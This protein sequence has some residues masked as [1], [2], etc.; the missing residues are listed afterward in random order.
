MNRVVAAIIIACTGLAACVSDLDTTREPADT[1]S[2]GNTVLTLVCKRIAYLEDLNDGDDIVDVRGDTFRDICRLGLAPP[3]AAPEELKALQAKRDALVAA[4]DTIFPE[5]FLSDLQTFLTSNEFL[6]LYDSGETMQAVDALIEFLR[7]LEA[8][9][10]LAPALE[11]FSLRLGYMP[12]TQALGAVRAFVNYPDLHEFLL[13]V[14]DQ[15]T[16]GG[17]AK[18]EWDNLI[19]GAAITMRA[20][21][22]PS[23]ANTPERTGQLA[24]DLLFEP[25]PLLDTSRTIPLVRRD[26]RGVAKVAMIGGSL[27]APFV[28]TDNDGLADVDDVGRFVDASNTP[29]AAPT[30][31]SLPSGEEQV[32]WLYRDAEGRALDSDG[33]Q[34]VYEY[35]DL[36][37]TMFA[38]LA[39]DS[40]QLFDPQ[41]GTALDLLRGASVLMGPRQLVTRAYNNGESIEYRGY[42]TSDAPILDMVHGYLSLMTDPNIYDVLAL[43][44]EI[45]TNHEQSIARILEAL[46]DTA[47]VGDAHPE[48]VIPTTSP[49]FDDL[50]PVIRQILDKPALARGLMRALENTQVAELGKRFRDYMKYKDQFTINPNNQAVVGSFST[51][52]DRNKSDSGYDRSLW[53]RLLHLIADS[54][55]AVLCNKDG[56]KVDLPGTGIGIAYYDECKLLRIDNLAV[57]YVQ[58]IAYAKDSNGN[59]II[60]GNGKPLPKA[61]FPFNLDD[62]RLGLPIAWAVSDDTLENESGIEGFRFNP[63]PE[64]LNRTLFL[65][66]MPTFLSNAMDPAKC[67]DGDLFTSAHGGTLPVWE[68]DGFYDQ[69]RPIV[70]VFADNNAEQLFVDMMVV[71]HK[72][73]PS[74][75][76]ITHQTTNPNGHGYAWGSGAVSYEPLLVDVLERDKLLPALV[77]TASDLNSIT[78]N[79]KSMPRIATEAARYM[80]TPQSGLAKRDG[81]TSTTTSD[82]ETVATLSPWHLLADAYQ[83]KRARLDAAG[84]EGGTWPSATSNLVD[85]LIRA[86]AVPNLGWTFRNPRFR[87]ISVGL[88]NFLEKRLQAHDS[89]SDRTDWL[90]TQLPNR[91]EEILSS[92]LFA[93]A[94][95]FFLSLQ[96]SPEARQQIEALAAYLVNEVNY[97]DAF[98]TSLSA[99]ADM[100]QLALDD[101]DILPI[102]RVVGEA[103]K[104]ERGWLNTHLEWVK[105]VRHSDANQ[106]LVRM[107]RN[108]YTEHRPG[109]TAVSDLIDGISE[110]KR[111]DP[112]EDL[113]KDYTAADYKALLLGVAG[114]LDEE[115]RGLRKFIR[116][117]ESRNK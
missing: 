63:T 100:L 46:V 10:D 15:I 28:D 24:L 94:A 20:A 64:A 29:V 27:P 35:L 17:Q 104:P 74:K 65:Q 14:G 16:E 60:G 51:P 58:S 4:V 23:D 43:S 33:G 39:R 22:T 26:Q 52:V 21:E 32:P 115:K 73:W 77:Y 50:V 45:F 61:R 56:A 116:I 44:R 48:A 34:P 18:V 98:M 101:R 97:N 88:I 19:R 102:A 75:D 53:Q 42:D 37:G 5:S 108:L 89:A 40:I 31:F 62:N 49:L 82:G 103:L 76:S 55:K 6:A 93:G 107:L 68:K 9:P 110:V 111:A 71:L 109:H 30:P 114:F 25:N 12:T 95:D 66:P 96:A 8:E 69:I 106:A 2:F 3:A 90:L 54:D 99:A 1:G 85:V 59:V 70:Q 13:V 117:I 11:R 105:K 80:L 41:K 38:A 78:T 7:F 84:A 113:G 79:G 112:W 92:P 86:D 67:K 57:F 91:A 83:A 72:H 87:G 47:R 36:D 81:S